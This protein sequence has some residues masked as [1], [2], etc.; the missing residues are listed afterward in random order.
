MVTKLDTELYLT[1]YRII[2]ISQN[3]VS[4]PY[5]Y[6]QDIALVEQS[7]MRIKLKTGIIFDIYP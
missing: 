6:V 2:I 5:G 4:I 7:K 3:P 1:N